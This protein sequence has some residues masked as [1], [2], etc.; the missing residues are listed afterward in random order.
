MRPA[1]E[2]AAGNGRAR[3]HETTHRAIDAEVAIIGAGPVRDLGARRSFRADGCGLA[4]RVGHDGYPTARVRQMRALGALGAVGACGRIQSHGA[5]LSAKLAA[6]ALAVVA[7]AAPSLQYEQASRDST[8]LLHAA[9]HVVV[10]VVRAIKRPRFSL[11]LACY[12]ALPANWLCAGNAIRFKLR[13]AGIRREERGT[14][15]TREAWRFVTDRAR[16]R[17]RATCCRFQAP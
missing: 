9:A 10:A 3:P 15:R 12:S 2:P 5:R 7:G 14:P 13:R 4:A 17:V 11:A 16:L 1:F 6:Q 8:V